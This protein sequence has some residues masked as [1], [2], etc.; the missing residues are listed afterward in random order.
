M[1][2]H[3]R[4]FRLTRDSVL[5]TLGLVGIAYETLAHQAERPTLLLLFAGMIG[6]PA[7]LRG[8]EHHQD[9]PKD[10]PHRQDDH[11]V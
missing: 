10:E 4:R 5:F 3:K 7:F 11:H 9:D 1:T 2:R 6:L 8:D